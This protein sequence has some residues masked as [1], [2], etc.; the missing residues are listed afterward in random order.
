MDNLSSISLIMKREGFFGSEED[1]LNSVANENGWI[2]QWVI[3]YE[4]SD[5]ESSGHAVWPT[6]VEF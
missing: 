3:R 4:S 6:I 2:F 1:A 5:N